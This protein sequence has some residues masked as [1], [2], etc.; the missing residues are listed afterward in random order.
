M[1]TDTL[2]YSEMSVE[3]LQARAGELRHDFS[4]L[5][6]G[7]RGDEYSESVRKILDEVNS[8]DTH[9]TLAL[10]QAAKAHIAPTAATGIIAGTGFR[11]VGEQIMGAD[12][13]T[14]WIDSGLSNHY[15]GGV[16]EYSFKG[17]IDSGSRAIIG[18]FGSGGPGNN[19]TDGVNSLLPVGQPVPP[20]PRMARLFMRD[21]IPVQPT[22]LTIVNYVRELNPVSLEGSASAVAEGNTKPDVGIS[23]TPAIASPTVIA[24]NISPTKQL[25]EDA[26]LV[27]AYINQRLPYLVRLKE[28]HEILNGSGTWPDITGILNTSGVQSQSFTNSDRAQAI[29]MSIA[30]VENVDGTASAVVMNPTD[31]WT[32]FTNRAS[33]SGVFDAGTPFSGADFGT[34]W[35]LPVMRSRAYSSGSCLVGDFQRGAMILDRETVNVQVYPQH[36]S[37]AA[38][39]AVLVQCEERVGLMVMRPDFFVNTTL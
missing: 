35:G 12:E 20:I 34:V 17:R 23:L 28:D 24:G 38:Q 39:N 31:A 37:Y 13:M 14:G 9:L 1:S 3:D 10:A 19:A 21:L 32:M 16:I 5:S 33:T 18:E 6:S 8:L 29:G 25:W 11:S 4:D 22:T 26:P 15:N 27:V 36:A 2:N 7:E 30:D